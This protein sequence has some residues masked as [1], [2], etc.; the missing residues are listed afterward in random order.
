[1]V[2]AYNFDLRSNGLKTI[3]APNPSVGTEHVFKTYRLRGDPI[4]PVKLRERSR[5]TI[6]QVYQDLFPQGDDGDDN[7]E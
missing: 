3:L 1:M 7:N 4:V 5:K 6:E 2:V